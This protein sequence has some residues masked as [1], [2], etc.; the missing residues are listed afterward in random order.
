M[1]FQKAIIRSVLEERQER[2]GKI[3]SITVAVTIHDDEIDDALNAEFVL[4]GGRLNQVLN[5]P[6]FGAALLN[7]IREQIAAAH[8]AWV[9][10]VPEKPKQ[11]SRSEIVDILGTDTITEL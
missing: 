5:A 10:E 7:W 11:R 6:D 4:R 2:A 8:T 3:L 1:A 9:G